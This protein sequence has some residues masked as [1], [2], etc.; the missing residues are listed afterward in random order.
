MVFSG[1]AGPLDG[2]EAVLPESP[3]RQ[4]PVGDWSL[5]APGGAPVPA[6]E[7]ELTR[8]MA[9]WTWE[10]AFDGPGHDPVAPPL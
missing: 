8:D 2:L 6:V 9:S 5:H 7:I 1:K 3:H 4:A 10:G